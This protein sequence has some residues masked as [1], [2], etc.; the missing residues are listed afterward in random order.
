MIDTLETNRLL[1]RVGKEEIAEAVFE[2]YQNN[3]DYF[4][5]YEPTRPGSFYTVDYHRTSLQYEYNEIL[6]HRSLRYYLYL[7]EY[8]DEI[9]GSVNFN[10]ILG[11]PFQHATLGYK[12]D[13][14]F[15][16]HGYAYEACLASITELFTN[17]PVRRIEAKVAPG[18]ANSIRLIER[19]G[20][21][22]EGLERE[23][24]EVNGKWQSHLRYSLLKHEFTAQPM[25]HS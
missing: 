14:R 8:P 2:F 20:F 12:L 10:G 25:S 7:R 24:V 22:Q 4:D 23:S 15:W 19:L 1:L 11:G 18:N 21:T 5:R 9:I 17:Y 6:R 13:R 16:G 3:R